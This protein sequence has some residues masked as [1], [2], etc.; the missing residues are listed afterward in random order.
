MG[1]SNLLVPTECP[2]CIVHYVVYQIKYPL[3]AHLNRKL[4]SHLLLD[5]LDGGPV[6]FLYPLVETGAGMKYPTEIVFGGIVQNDA[7][8][9]PLPG[10]RVNPT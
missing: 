4:V 3:D 9:N 6:K 1:S 10:I 7:V 2:C 8:R 5:F